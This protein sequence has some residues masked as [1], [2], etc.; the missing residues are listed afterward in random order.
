M[1]P[2][3]IG[4]FPILDM[5]EQQ[6]GPSNGV[7]T[8]QPGFSSNPSAPPISID[9]KNTAPLPV[10]SAPNLLPSDGTF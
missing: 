8:Q 5:Q 3:I 2:I 6:P 7:N 10:P 4:I 9:Q 1:L